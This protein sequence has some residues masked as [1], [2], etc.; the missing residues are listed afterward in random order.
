MDDEFMYP[1]RTCLDSNDRE[2]LAQC[3]LVNHFTG[4]DY[5]LEDTCRSRDFGI[6]VTAGQIKEMLRVLTKDQLRRMIMNI[7][8]PPPRDR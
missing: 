3:V 2:T 4:P 6:N 1:S 7:M 8:P 5:N